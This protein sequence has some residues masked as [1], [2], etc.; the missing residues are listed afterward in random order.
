LNHFEYCHCNQWGTFRW[1]PSYPSEMYDASRNY[2]I[3]KTYKFG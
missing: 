1:D 3:A 2:S